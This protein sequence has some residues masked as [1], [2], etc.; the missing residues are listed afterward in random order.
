M[1]SD[2]V[3]GGFECTGKLFA[4]GHWDVI[5][6]IMTMAKSM[7]CGYLPL[8]ATIVHRHIGDFFKDLFF[9]NGAADAGHA[10]D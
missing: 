8:G 9:Y 2:E 6:D 1:I 5:P 4:M 3:T 10:L 7:T